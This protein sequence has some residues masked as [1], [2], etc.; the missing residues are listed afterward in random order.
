MKQ[1]LVQPPQNIMFVARSAPNDVVAR[2]PTIGKGLAAAAD[3]A[4]AFVATQPQQVVAA[5]L[6]HHFQQFARIVAVMQACQMI[7]KFSQY[8]EGVRHFGIDLRTVSTIV[9]IA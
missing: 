6:S 7:G 1:A 2:V 4:L 3:A 5:V 9:P 8:P